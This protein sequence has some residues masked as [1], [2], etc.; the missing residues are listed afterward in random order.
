MASQQQNLDDIFKQAILLI[1]NFPND[2]AKQQDAVKLL[3][4]IE[5]L[6][7]ANFALCY[8]LLEGYLTPM[9]TGK[10]LDRWNNNSCTHFCSKD[11]ISFLESLPPSAFVSTILGIW[12]RK[13]YN[14]ADLGQLV[15]KH[16]TTA[17]LLNSSLAETALGIYY[18]YGA[19]GLEQDFTKAFQWFKKAAD[20]DFAVACNQIGFCYSNAEGVP[21]DNSKAVFYFTKAASKGDH[22][23]AVNIA[24][25]YF[26]GC[27]IEQDYEKCVEWFT[28]AAEGGQDVAMRNL[29]VFYRDGLGPVQ[30]NVEKKCLLECKM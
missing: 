18:V 3:Y 16:L 27:G 4:S 23:A 29:S 30:P 2:I 13:S 11:T 21:L 26:K 14:E 12:Y 9:D 20:K 7:I 1:T 19:G 8:C 24:N 17:S 6:N 5:N 15:L 25:H 22:S 28:V 10:G